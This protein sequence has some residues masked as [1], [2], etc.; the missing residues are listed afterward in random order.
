MG[1]SYGMTNGAE[2]YFAPYLLG[3][4][5]NIFDRLSQ[6][7]S[8]SAKRGDDVVLTVDAQLSN[9]AYQLLGGRAGSIVVSNYKT[10]LLYTSNIEP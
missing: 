7:V 8:G 4:N 1:D 5:S 2:S 3:F 9:Y 10:C 6:A